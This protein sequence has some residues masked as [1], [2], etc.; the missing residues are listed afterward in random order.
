[1]EPT[2]PARLPT[3]A[4]DAAAEATVAQQAA[5]SAEQ[6]ARLRTLTALGALGELAPEL[7][8]LRRELRVRDQ[9]GEVRPPAPVV[10]PR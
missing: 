3:D 8:E 4:D 7:R 2:E 5:L 10:W 6:D 9:R 1:M